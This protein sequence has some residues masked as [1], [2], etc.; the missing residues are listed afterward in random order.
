[1]DNSLLFKE[2][3][4]IQLLE[5]LSGIKIPLISDF[6]ELSNLIKKIS[7]KVLLKI[8]Y[9][10][11]SSI[12]KILFN[13]DKFIKISIA[14]IN[15]DL[16]SFY[17]LYKIIIE[18]RYEINYIYNYD[19]ILVLY[20]KI[21]EQSNKINKITKFILCI[22]ANVIIFNFEGSVEA[23]NPKDEEKIKNIKNEIE[24]FMRSQND[25]VDEFQLN[26]DLNNINSINIDIIYVQIIRSLIKNRKIYNDY[27]FTENT[28]EQLGLENIELE[29][30]MCLLLK[31]EFDENPDDDYIK[32]YIIDNYNKLI[33][34][35]YINFYYLILKYVFK[36]PTHP[37]IISFLWKS[38]SSIT[39]IAQI[40]LW[41][42]LDDIDNLG[43]CAKER[44]LYVLKIFLDLPLAYTLEKYFDVKKTNMEKKLRVFIS[45]LENFYYMP[46]CSILYL[47]IK[48]SLF[49]KNLD[50]LSNNIKKAIFIFFSNKLNLKTYRAIL[51]MDSYK[52]L[53]DEIQKAI[54]EILKYYKAFLPNSKYNE[55]QSIIR[56]D[57]NGRIFEDFS[58]A[59]KRNLR[60][61]LIF[62]FLEQA[63]NY[64]EEQIKDA[65][66]KWNKIEKEINNKHFYNLSEE[67][68]QKLNP[69]FG[70]PNNRIIHKI[71]RKEIIEAYNAYN[72]SNLNESQNILDESS[73]IQSFTHRTEYHE[74]NVLTY[75]SDENENTIRRR[76]SANINNPNNI[77]SKT[78]LKI[79]M[80]KNYEEKN[81]EIT[82]SSQ[83][84]FIREHDIN[85]FTNKY[86]VASE[87]L[88]SPN[89]FI[90]KLYKG[91]NNGY[92]LE[93]NINKN[94]NKFIFKSKF[95]PPTQNPSKYFIVYNNNEY[96]FETQIIPP[97]Q[98]ES[99]QQT[100][101]NYNF[102]SY[103]FH[104]LIENFD[105]E[106]YKQ[107]N[108]SLE[109]KNVIDES[110][111]NTH[112]ED[113]I[114][115]SSIKMNIGKNINVIM[116]GINGISFLRQN[117]PSSE[118]YSKYPCRALIQISENS[119]A[120]ISEGENE[121]KL[122]FYNF[123]NRNL[124]EIDIEHHIIDASHCLKA[125]TFSSNNR[126]KERYLICA[127]KKYTDK[128]N[129]G[130]FLINNN[131]KN[132]KDFYNSGEF[133]VY[134]LFQICVEMK[135][136]NIIINCEDKGEKTK[137]FLA[138][139]FDKSKNKCQ[140][141][142]FKI[143]TKNNDDKDKII[144][145]QDLEYLNGEI[146]SV[147]QLKNLLE[148]IFY[149]TL[150]R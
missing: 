24:E 55:I 100:F 127:C 146:T 41:N 111:T 81:F 135:D 51:D 97:N 82:F 124:E 83:G 131:N 133:E 5:K 31:N 19:V 22:F 23:L 4:L 80:S 60:K 49:D 99:E 69:Y 67:D 8:S 139:G 141:K 110:K 108:I 7:E 34:I 114:F 74:T 120:F 136:S 85:N 33:D 54:N 47:N 103:G 143:N 101:Y 126:I 28:L 104:N 48:S 37:Y 32:F 132:S 6:A 116:A 128:Q 92:E 3:L 43:D 56:G 27:K 102:P 106:K 52:F 70:D 134:C 130:I 137:F 18:K 16:S 79:K 2:K 98:D 58:K 87:T 89:D 42:L 118:I 109:I 149:A 112:H 40:D 17:Y 145:L 86:N 125:L 123:Y 36:D 14:N 142:L 76:N 29:Y 115:S 53:L 63:N 75:F 119:I 64:T 46:S 148:I 59:V 61:E 95:I 15:S 25:L 113:K 91:Y 117:N 13:E 144:F 71:F 44:I 122:N 62:L 78:N 93:I 21:K 105:R 90:D 107:T 35:N 50:K 30:E 84:I 121:E 65:I 94:N 147:I 150:V 38:K 1:M 68:K 10:Y 39:N 66:K 11:K 140:I 129:N 57:I 73:E 96:K 77:N 26:I 20:N 72:E 12:S 9:H 45:L 88:D 138:G